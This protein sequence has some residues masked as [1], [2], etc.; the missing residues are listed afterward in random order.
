MADGLDLPPRHRATIQA[1]LARHLPE[2]EAWAYG[3]RM[4]G[5]SHAGSDL[6]LV[7]RGPGLQ[8][9]PADRLARL[10]EAFRESRIPFLVEARDWALLPA[11]FRRRIE[12]KHVVLYGN[13]ASA[14]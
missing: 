14:N 9:I 12:R 10:R 1:L 6:D 11:G 4:A 5:R 13:R 2:V 7:L 8:P 3:S